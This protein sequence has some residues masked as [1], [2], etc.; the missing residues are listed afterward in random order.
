MYEAIQASENL[1][2]FSES[3]D[4]NADPE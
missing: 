2:Y 3:M 4:E 1:T